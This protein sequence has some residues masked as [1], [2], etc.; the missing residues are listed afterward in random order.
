[1]A[2]AKSHFALITGAS[3]GIGFE[4]ARQFAGHGYDLMIC[5]NDGP[6]L[7]DA[8][9]SLREEFTVGVWAVE[10]DL[11]LRNG[12]QELWDAYVA[13]DRPLD[14]L[15]ANA[16]AGVA[17]SFL[18]TDLGDE[19]D[20]I[21]LNVSGQVHLCKLGLRKMQAQ[22]HGGLLLTSSLIAL[23]PGPFMAIYAASK[24]FLHSF[25]LA[26]RNELRDTP[27]TVT[28]LM[29]GATE[30][31]FWK[32]ADMED[33]I[34]GESKKDAPKKVAKEAF[35]A[36]RKGSAYVVPGYANKAR[37]GLTALTPDTVLAQ[38]NRDKAQ[39]AG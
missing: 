24:A 19:L 14:A 2:D 21:E 35:D 10:A 32:R 12:V 23:S 15:V 38:A 26:V 22:G 27:L 11:R 5:S 20:T 30:T 29:P 31:D 28:V 17:G 39:E 1:M 4:L 13:T 37:A 25:G 33:T 36:F 3:S 18:D 9:R 34:I 16:G 8:E 7:R 6:Q